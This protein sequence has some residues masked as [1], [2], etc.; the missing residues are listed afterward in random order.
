M[1]LRTTDYQ[2][3][4]DAMNLGHVAYICGPNMSDN[5]GR[6][7]AIVKEGELRYCWFETSQQENALTPSMIANELAVLVRWIKESIDGVRF[8]SPLTN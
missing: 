7:V 8:L 1:K 6:I 4:A 5:R 2:E 3:S